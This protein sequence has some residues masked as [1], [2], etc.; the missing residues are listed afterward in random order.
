[1]K[2]L[3]TGGTGFIGSNLVSRLVSDGVDVI[4]SGTDGE[5][6]PKNFVGLNVGRDFSC[7][8][9]KAV[10]K[11]DVV[12]HEAAITDT[13]CYDADE[14]FRVNVHNSLKLFEGALGAGCKRF[15]FASSAAVYGNADVP[16]RESGRVLPLNCYA[17]SKLALENAAMEFASKNSGVVAVGLRYC[18]VYGPGEFYKGR[19][20][21]M[22]YQFA[23][24]MLKGNPRLFKWGEQKRDYVYVGDVV[25][26]N[27]LASKSKESC[28]V[29]CGSGHA[30]SFNDLVVMLNSVLGLNRT[31]EYFDNPYV[32]KYQNHTCCDMSF[33]DEKL[34]FV[35]AFYLRKG[36][37]DYLSR[38][39]LV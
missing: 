8:N 11:V 7:I 3:V 26:V 1:M 2:A 18:N 22:I 24:Q 19:T 29:N 4:I 21:T 16:F 34:G 23:Q 6:K 31:P 5:L 17:E 28:V 13:A 37:E 20:S 35:P 36:I 27:V 33:A 30:V 10:G 25:E 32:G 39:L 14:M 38:G 15:V 12:F 9:W